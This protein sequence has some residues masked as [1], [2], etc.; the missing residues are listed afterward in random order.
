MSDGEDEELKSSIRL[1][2]E[3]AEAANDASS[4]IAAMKG[5]VE[6]AADRIDRFARSVKPLL[7]GV[8]VGSVTVI[9]LGSLMYFRTLSEMRTA[10]ATQLEAL[11]MF[12]TSVTELNEQLE[13][14]GQMTDHL[15]NYQTSQDEGM[16]GLGDRIDGSATVVATQIAQEAEATRTALSEAITANGTATQEALVSGM[17][18]LQLALSRMLADGLGTQTSSTS[19]TQS[20]ATAASSASNDAPAAAATPARPARSTATTPRRAAAPAPNPFRV[21]Q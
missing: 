17:S 3:A 12:S 20:S 7:L 2:L 19:T 18:D 5:D 13:F 15:A 10:T 11:T 6:A 9:G 8:L 14:V 16:T 1:A 4:E 21:S